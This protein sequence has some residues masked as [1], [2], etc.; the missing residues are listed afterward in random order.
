MDDKL[1]IKYIRKK[2]EIGIEMLIDE[3]G[4]YI[5]SIIRKYLGE[6]KSYEEECVNDVLMAVWDNIKKYDGTKGTLRNWIGCISKYKAINYK[7]KYIREIQNCEIDD[8]TVSYIDT[9]LEIKELEEE[10][11]DLLSNLGERDKNIFR[12]YYIDDIS[13][14][15]IAKDE[16]TNVNNLYNRI[17]RGRKKLR[18]LYKL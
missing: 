3:Y 7:K 1:L 16:N 9:D 12:K 2:K 5:T 17:S 10:V 15:D 6:F 13:L 18:D 4:D 8:N 11:E 14:E